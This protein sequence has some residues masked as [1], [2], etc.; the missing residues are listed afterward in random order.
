MRGAFV[1]EKHPLSINVYFLHKPANTFANMIKTFSRLFR[2]PF[3]Q[4]HCHNG[5]FFF[6]LSQS[7][8]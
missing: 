2:Y 3:M 7:R 1:R 4:G 5:L 8:F 6:Q